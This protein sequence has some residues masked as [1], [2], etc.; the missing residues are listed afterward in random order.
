MTRLSTGCILFVSSALTLSAASQLRLSSSTIGPVYVESASN[1]AGQTIY[2]FNL[3]DGSLN[4]SVSSSASWLSGSLGAPTTC[5]SGPVSGCIPIA[6]TLNVSGLAIGNYSETLTVAD[7]N[8]IDAPQIITVTVQV[9]G[10]PTSA[11][12][13]VTP[14]MGAATAQSDTGF[15]TVNTGGAVISSVTTSD[16]TP[17]LNFVLFGGNQVTFTGYQIRVTSQT[18]QAEGNYTGT[19]LLSG[20]TYSPD[21]KTINVSLHVT[22][23]PIIQNVPIT[24]NVV[25]GGP[26][27]TSNINFQNLGMGTLNIS[28]ATVSAGSGLSVSPSGGSGVSLTADPSSLSPGSYFATLTLA[29]NA[30]NTATPISVRVNVLANTGGP[31]ISFAGVVD[32]AA[33]ASGQAVAAGSIAALFGIQLSTNAPAFASGFPL[34]T[35][36]GGVQ[37]LINGNPA[38]LFYADFGQIDFQVP[39]NL[40]TGQVLVQ[41]MRNGQPGNR[42]STTIDSIAPRLFVLKQFG[43]APDGLPYGLVLNS[44]NTYAAPAQGASNHPATRG[45]IVTIYALGLGPVSPP[46]NTGDPAPSNEPLA[47]TTTQVQVMYGGGGPGAVGSM[48]IYAGL[49]PGFA[50]LYQI[51]A[52]VPV[53]APTGNVP[54]SITMPGHTSNVVEM[55]IQ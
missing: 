38:P 23:Q 37:V 26:P 6:V 27:Q 49:A 25:N 8:A 46:V 30:A 16:S 42:I 19:V 55:A 45:S 20:S 44:D 33:F 13:Y 53:T 36:L 29:S 15:L 31:R 34:P 50:G 24:F 5:A 47:R 11:D 22:S 12:F 2:A 52:L 3:G 21:N 51:D 40:S 39:F 7:P 9:S 48:A 14:N 1:A 10:S 32:N 43:A 28:G 4:L 17:W 18:G 54:V 41:V 35:T